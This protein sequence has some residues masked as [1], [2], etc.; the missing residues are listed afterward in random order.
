MVAGLGVNYRDALPFDMVD[1]K[2]DK[3]TPAGFWREAIAP[4]VDMKE[5]EAAPRTWKRRPSKVECA[6]V[7]E[8]EAKRR[9]SLGR[10]PSKIIQEVSKL[11]LGKY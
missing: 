4:D 7:D 1:F 10:R 2:L 3:E 5:E 11:I 9:H 8:L 6:V